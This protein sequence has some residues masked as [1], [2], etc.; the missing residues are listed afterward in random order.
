MTRLRGHRESP[1]DTVRLGVAVALVG[2]VVGYSLYLLCTGTALTDLPLA[3]LDAAAESALDTLSL[4]MNH[5]GRAVILVVATAVLS[6]FAFGR[7]R[8]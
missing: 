7:R 8:R 3:L 6:R 5:P 2:P 1:L 4:A